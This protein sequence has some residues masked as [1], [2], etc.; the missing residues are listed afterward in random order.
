MMRALV[1]V[2]LACLLAACAQPLPLTAPAG[3]E[4]APIRTISRLEQH[5]RLWRAG[6]RDTPVRYD[7]DTYRMTY[8]VQ[9]AD[10]RDE[11]ASGLLA[12]PRGAHPRT[13][14][15]Y[16]HGTTATRGNVPSTLKVAGREAMLAFAGAGHALVA[17]DYLGL[18]ASELRHPYLIAD[19]QARSVVSMIEAARQIKGVPLGPV[20][21]TGH[22]EGGHASLAAMRLLEANGEH[23]LGAAPIAAAYDLDG[24]SFHM[25]TQS[26]LPIHAFYLGY[27]SWA[28]ADHY[29][30]PLDT[31][32]TP[33]TARQV[34][35]LFD[36]PASTTNSVG[37]ALTDTPGQMLNPDVLRAA[38][39]HEPHWF[40]D[41]LAQNSLNDFTLRGP[42]RFYYGRA[43]TEVAPQESIAT[44]EQMHARGANVEAVDLGPIGHEQSLAAAVPRILEW[45]E[46]LKAAR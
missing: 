30:R 6:F 34:Q 18:G 3:V 43:D 33:D 40:L 12:L 45:I 46:N 21:L 15:S 5:V 25:A 4:L 26:E 42:V 29:R 44:A 24:V 27:T 9:L 17:P 35:A 41:A 19:P 11:I 10:G 1:G 39:A 23:V 37:R 16:Q 2:L 32:L 38:E 13:L 22:S 8:R 7:I 14:V 28:Y 31:V 36:D 20:F